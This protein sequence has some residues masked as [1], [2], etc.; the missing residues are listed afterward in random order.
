MDFWGTGA[1][2][3]SLRIQL[4][5]RGAAAGEMGGTPSGADSSRLV[6][7]GGHTRRVARE[8]TGWGWAVYPPVLCC[9][10]LSPCLPWHPLGPVPGEG[11]SW[12]RWACEYLQVC[13][14]WSEAELV[15]EGVRGTLQNWVGTLFCVLVM[16]SQTLL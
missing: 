1:L 3:I 2:L 9:I 10:T 6:L 15:P 16:R 7:A 11:L 13:A 5:S 8:G 12:G 4:V 14:T